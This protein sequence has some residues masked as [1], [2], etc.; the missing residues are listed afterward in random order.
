MREEVKM[1]PLNVNMLVG[2]VWVGR[3]LRDEAGGR[4]LVGGRGKVPIETRN[5][6]LRQKTLNIKIELVLEHDFHHETFK[7]HR[8]TIQ[9][10]CHYTL[11]YCI[12]R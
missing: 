10:L 7:P 11:L 6:K 9:R 8:T 3:S 5:I 1:N 12:D 2:G 4:L